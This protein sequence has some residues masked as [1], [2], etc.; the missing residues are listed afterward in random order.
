MNKVASGK[1][2]SGQTSAIQ[3]RLTPL[4]QDYKDWRT[5]FSAKNTPNYKHT[6][7]TEAYNVQKKFVGRGDLY[8]VKLKNPAIVHGRGEKVT[9]IH[10]T[11]FG[12]FMNY[13]KNMETERSNEKAFSKV[14]KQGPKAVN[15]FRLRNTSKVI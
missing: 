2:P 6:G 10:T 7:G 8:N 5:D 4:N 1:P 12:D 15:Q 9:A 14:E 13:H 11:Q 3:R